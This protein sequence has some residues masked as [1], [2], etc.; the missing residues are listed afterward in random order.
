M[1][2]KFLFNINNSIN[3]K[4]LNNILKICNKSRSTSSVYLTKKIGYIYFLV[5][6]YNIVYIGA[7]QDRNRI[8][9]HQKTKDFDEV[10]YY[11]F[12][13]NDNVFWKYESLLIRNFKTKYNKDNY[14]LSNCKE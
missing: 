6:N 10:Y 1:D 7:S 12:K 2:F 9:R 11:E 8:G 3:L 13:N 5:K 14:G 4:N